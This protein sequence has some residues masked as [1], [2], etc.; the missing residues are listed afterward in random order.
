MR[1]GF[2]SQIHKRKLTF[3]TMR[4]LLLFFILGWSLTRTY[5]QTLHIYGG[6]NQEEYLGC[7]NCDRFNANSIWNAYGTYGSRY[8]ANS[9]WN[10][11]G[12]YGS[13]FNS[14]SPW[15][16]YSSEAPILVDKQGNFYGYFTVN[17]Y[18]A[19]RAE[20]N[21]LEVI[22]EYHEFIREDVAKWYCN[23]PRIWDHASSAPK[24]VI[25]QLEKEQDQPF[26]KVGQLQMDNDFLKKAYS[27]RPKSFECK[28]H[29]SKGKGF[30]Y[31]IIPD[32][33]I[34]HAVVCGRMG[35]ERKLVY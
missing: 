11:Y 13:Q 18:R 17:P 35:R 24:Q 23:T 4:I 32:D 7:L 22:Y 15:N 30:G 6:A 2:L 16:A 8:N 10:P 14:Y 28:R 12:T 1:D 26:K 29:E 31:E 21:L 33:G 20:S 19:S 25:L 5:C 9:I 27:P 3:Y 34:A